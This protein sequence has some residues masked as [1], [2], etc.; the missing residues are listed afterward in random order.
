[1]KIDKVT[2]ITPSLPYPNLV[3]H[4]LMVE[5]GPPLIA[6]ITRNAGYDVRLFAEHIAPVDWQ[7]VIHSDVVCFHTFSSTM[8]KVIEYCRRIRA[9][10]PDMPIIVGGT[11]A[12]VMAE[13][14]LQYCDYVVRQ[15]GDETLPELLAAL[16]DGG[17]LSSVLGIS[18]KVDGGIR[19]N[20]NRPFIEQLDTVP[21]MELIHGYTA[22]SKLQLARRLMTRWN[23]LQTS[24][25]CPYDCS[26]CIA[27]REL[28][29]GYRVR[30]IENVIADIKYQRALTGCKRFFIVDNHFTVN[31]ERTKALLNRI[32]EEKL[33]WE[34]LCFTRV[35]VARDK[36]MLQ[37]LKKSG[38]NTLYMGLE[39]FDNDVLKVLN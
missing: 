20:P 28:G 33:D 30:D 34:A 23:V 29:R 35:E 38:I 2:F 21:D 32:I 1:M 24:R 15:E 9:R 8:P 7:R 10:R 11:H 39:S 18:Y 27:P 4:I 19:H 5:Y 13:D 22:V 37:L 25:G 36:E 3:S 6:T 26:F 12:S 17:D 31:R 16:R 14:T